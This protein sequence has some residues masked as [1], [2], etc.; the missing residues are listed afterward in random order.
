[1]SKSSNLIQSVDRAMMLL[2]AVAAGHTEGETVAEL[3]EACGLQRATAWR[4]L[5]TLESRGF[6]HSSGSTHRYRLGPAIT[7]LASSAGVLGFEHYA[8][9]VLE[10]LSELTGETASLAMLRPEG[11]TYIAEV[12]PPRVL[13][14]SWLGHTTELH[15]T[16]TGKAFLA[17]LPAQEAAALLPEKLTAH[18]DTTITSHSALAKEL[19]QIT[20]TGFAVC[21]GELESTLYGVSAPV[22]NDRGQ[23]YAVVSVWGPRSR[24]P[25]SRLTEFGALTRT[26]AARI[27]HPKESS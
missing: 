10:E 23:P 25:D 16:S 24:L 11:L 4:L 13:T 5:A 6:L 14:A 1:M 12:T 17:F 3:A 19:Q 15:A 7:R 26:A 18:T 27:A 9:Q 21:R 2:E 22:L 8:R 20:D